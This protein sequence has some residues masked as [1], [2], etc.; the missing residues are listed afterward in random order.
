MAPLS[1]S[2]VEARLEEHPGWAREGEAIVKRFK[3]GDFMGSVAFVNAL[4]K[5]AEEMN[6]HPDV[7]ISWD[8]VTV[9]LSTHSEGGITA[10]D[11]E[12]AAKVDAL[13]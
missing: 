1:D 13:A 10:A 6:H 3:R 8:E 4:A 9:S 11:F 12:L 7:A 5:P 2:E